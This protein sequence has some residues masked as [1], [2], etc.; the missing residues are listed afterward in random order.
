MTERWL[1]K[2]AVLWA[3]YEAEKVP[4]HLLATLIV[5]AMHTSAEGKG[6]FISAAT[7]AALTRKSERNA[8]KDLAELRRLGL[9]VPGNQLLTAHIRCD[10]RPFVYDLPLPVDNSPAG[11]SHT[12]SRNGHGVSHT[13]RRGVAEGPDGVSHTTPEEVLKTSGKGGRARQGERARRQD[14][15]K[16]PP[17]TECGKPFSQEE[18]ADPDFRTMALASEVIHVECIALERQR[19]DRKDPS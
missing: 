9:V 19:L 17:C 4:A 7:V 6:A 13:T 8:K 10:R 2:P 5:V 14:Q 16:A 1:S 15:Y 11:V 18:L 12:T 3:I